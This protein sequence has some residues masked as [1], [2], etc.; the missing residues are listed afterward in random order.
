MTAEKTKKKAEEACPVPSGKIDVS[1]RALALLPAVPLFYE[2][3]G[4]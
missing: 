4:F 3:L 2:L 1:V